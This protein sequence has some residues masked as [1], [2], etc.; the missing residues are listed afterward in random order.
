MAQAS[1]RVWLVE[2][3]GESRKD[4][5]VKSPLPLIG[6]WQGLFSGTKHLETALLQ[7]N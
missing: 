3:K 2:V 4:E 5:R 7:F 1:I 6:L